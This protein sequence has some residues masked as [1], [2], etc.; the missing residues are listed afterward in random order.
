[1]AIPAKFLRE[2]FDEPLSDLRFVRVGRRH[3]WMRS[4][5]GIDHA[6]S[7]EGSHGSH[8]VR[9]DVVHPAVGEL[10]HGR[11]TDR[12]D[13]AYSGVITGAAAPALRSGVVASF[14]QEDTEEQGGLVAGVREAAVQVAGWLDDFEGTVSAIGYLTQD[15]DVPDRR[16]V[17][18]AHTPLRLYVAAGL[19]ASD[20]VPGAEELAER[21]IESL[22]PFTDSLT[23]E[24]IDRLRAAL[25]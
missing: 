5:D 10:L 2:A 25:V 18:P 20:G 24:R 1:M 15:F 12:A 6:I 16:V 9:W 4:G 14:R 11:H 13:V 17:F 22:T 3:V 21:A 23:S 8:K 7:L 19:A